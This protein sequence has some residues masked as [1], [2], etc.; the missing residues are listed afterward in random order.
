MHY[1]ATWDQHDLL[2][3]LPLFQQTFAPLR[4]GCLASQEGGRT[5]DKRP[6]AEAAEMG[7]VVE[8]VRAR[9]S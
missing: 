2:L 5:T 3:A 9:W 8:E 4:P 7:A 1:S 6:P